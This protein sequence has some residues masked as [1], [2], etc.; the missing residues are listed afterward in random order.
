MK[1]NQQI[2]KQI[3]NQATAKQ[4]NTM[5]VMI[6]TLSATAGNISKACKKANIS[7]QCHYDYFDNFDIYRHNVNDINEGIIDTAQTKLCEAIDKGEPWAIQFLLK[8]LGKK[9]GYTENPN[10]LVNNKI[11]NSLKV[12]FLECDDL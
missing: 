1:P 10:I 3:K 11:N 2:K 4:K 6:K 7:R 8:T 12:E 9:R 5:A